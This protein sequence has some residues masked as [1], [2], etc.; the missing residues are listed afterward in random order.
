MNVSVWK[1]TRSL[2]FCVENRPEAVW[3]G[4]K[5]D[6]DEEAIELVRVRE[7]ADLL[8]GWTVEKEQVDI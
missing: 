7:R 1:W 4:R 8:R 6:S 5:L 3:G 2:H